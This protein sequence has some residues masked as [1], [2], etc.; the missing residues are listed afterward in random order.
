[1]YAACLICFQIQIPVNN[2]DTSYLLYIWINFRFVYEKCEYTI[3]RSKL[4]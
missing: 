2:F 1:M 3:D 4:K